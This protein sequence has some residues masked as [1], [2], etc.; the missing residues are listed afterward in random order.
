MALFGPPNIDKLQAR[1]DVD[2][3]IK[4]LRYKDASMR[5]SAARALGEIGDARAVEPLLSTLKDQDKGVRGWSAD[6][7]GKIGDARAVEPLLA[8]LKHQDNDEWFQ[9]RAADALEWISVAQRWDSMSWNEQIQ[10]LEKSGDARVLEPFLT[11]LKNDDSRIQRNAI[12]T[13]AEVGKPAVEPLLAVLRDENKNLRWGAVGALGRI[14]D[15]RAFEPLC[16]AL[17]DNSEDV[18]EAAAWALGKIGDT[19][20]VGPLQAALKDDDKHV[21][22]AAEMASS[23]LKRPPVRPAKAESQAVESHEQVRKARPE[24]AAGNVLAM[25]IVY[26]GHVIEEPDPVAIAK[27]LLTGFSEAGVLTGVT[28]YPHSGIRIRRADES[29]WYSG[30]Y[31]P[32]DELPQML[33]EGIGDLRDRILAA[34]QTMGQV[35][36][37]TVQLKGRSRVVST[38]WVGIHILR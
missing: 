37:R 38:C 31:E 16:A 3:L 8:V 6:A 10:W 29:A 21:R 2:K 24:L 19:R 30:N 12:R 23:A 22:E 25:A 26:E 28:L 5:K 9:V 20:A 35:N 33:N 7:L 34:G 15:A 32:G 17:K 1:R 4:A 11:A 13:L 36:T 27:E 18:R 14:G